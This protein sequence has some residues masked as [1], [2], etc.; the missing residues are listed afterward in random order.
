MNRQMRSAAVRVTA[1]VL[2]VAGVGSVFAFDLTISLDASLGDLNAGRHV[3]G[4]LEGANSSVDPFDRPEPPAPPAAFL[5]LAFTMPQYDGPLPNAWREEY[6]EPEAIGDDHSEIWHVVVAT[7]GVPGDLVLS[8]DLDAGWGIEF[9]LRYLGPPYDEI[10]VP[11][12]GTLT[13]PLA[14]PDFEFWLEIYSEGV[15][16][17]QAQTWGGVKAVFR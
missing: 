8:C 6:R 13:V 3:F 2:C 11:V 17:A 14:G 9:T 15:V 4:V 16:G 5:R 10:E 12:P 1:I 7:D